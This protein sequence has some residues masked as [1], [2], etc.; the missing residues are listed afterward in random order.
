MLS[1]VITL[2]FNSTN[3]TLILLRKLLIMSQATFCSACRRYCQTNKTKAVTDYWGGRRVQK[4]INIYTPSNW[5]HC[6][7]QVLCRTCM[8]MLRAY[9]VNLLVLR[10][11]QLSAVAPHITLRS[12]STNTAVCLFVC[13]SV[14]PEFLKVNVTSTE[15]RLLAGSCTVEWNKVLPTRVNGDQCQSKFCHPNSATPVPELVRAECVRCPWLL[16]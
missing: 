15:A 13:L 1:G 16:A 8:R 7:S 4:Y 11:V 5:R 14:C 3:L 2:C 6:S 9:R 12:N 10:V